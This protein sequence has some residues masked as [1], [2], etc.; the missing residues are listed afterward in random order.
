MT[1]ATYRGADYVLWCSESG[2]SCAVPRWCPHLDWDLTEAV[3]VGEELVCPG[4]GWSIAV[5]G[6]VFKRNELGR[7]DDKGRVQLVDI[8][9]LED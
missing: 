2:R 1:A 4:H 8:A 7:E 5:D 6:R 3:V 9:E